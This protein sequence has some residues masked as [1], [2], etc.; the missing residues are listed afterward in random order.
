MGKYKKEDIIHRAKDLAKMIAATEEVEFF[1]QAEEKIHENT[2]V[3]ETLSMIKGLQKQA[4]NFQQYGKEK[5][6][7]QV[8]EKIATL[9]SDLDEIPIVQQFKQSQMEVNDLLQLVA[10]TVSNTVT[11]EIIA[12]TSGDVLKG[13]TGAQIRHKKSCQHD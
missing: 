12:A 6:L 4:V 8:E 1:K 7:K 10:L 9:E 3:A 13:Q 5:A 2:K 11:D